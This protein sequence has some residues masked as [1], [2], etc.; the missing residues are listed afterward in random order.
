VGEVLEDGAIEFKKAVVNGWR[1]GPVRKFW[2]IHLLNLNCAA[3][4][5]AVSPE[6]DVCRDRYGDLEGDEDRFSAMLAELEPPGRRAAGQR[7]D[8]YPGLVLRT[9][10]ALNIWTLTGRVPITDRFD[11]NRQQ[12]SAV[13]LRDSALTR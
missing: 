5:L 13:N 2:R 9:S 6:T 10:V 7:T 11:L 12:P 8:T 1:S 4:A 3:G